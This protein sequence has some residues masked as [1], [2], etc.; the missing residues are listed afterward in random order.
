M[1]TENVSETPS[2]C[3]EKMAFKKHHCHKGGESNAL[4]G[5]GMFGAAAY[6]L[7]GAHGFMPVITALAKA[8][9]WPAFLVFKIFTL[10]HI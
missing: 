4:Y 2:C 1:K 5:V 10:L 8:L 9:F 3:H 6:F 7:Q